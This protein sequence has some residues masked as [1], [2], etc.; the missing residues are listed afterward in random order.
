[1]HKKIILIVL[2]VI[3]TTGCAKIEKEDNDYNKLIVNC[4]TKDKIT[5]E[6]AQGYKFYIPKGVKL[7]KNYEYNQKFLI[8][9]NYMYLYVDILS[10]YYKKEINY[11]SESDSYYYNKIS[12]NGKKGYIKITKDENKY[13]VKIIYNYS[14]IEIYTDYENLNK[15]ISLGTIILNNIKY[16]KKIIKKQI[17]ESMGSFGEVTYEIEKPEDASN[18]FSQYLEEYVQE[19]DEDKET[20]KK[21]PDE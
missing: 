17:E 5:N 21:L 3:L 1:M 18:K 16:N 15:T 19:E 7:I 2:L 14:K 20:I 11:E 10:Y 9:K 6:V 12:Y 13:L 8:D 4:L